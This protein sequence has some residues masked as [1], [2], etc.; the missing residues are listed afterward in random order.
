MYSPQSDTLDSSGLVK[1]EYP[2]TDYKDKGDS[3]NTNTPTTNQSTQANTNNGPNTPPAPQNNTAATSSGTNTNGDRDAISD[4]NVNIQPRWGDDDSLILTIRDLYLEPDSSTGLPT[5]SIKVEVLSE[6][7]VTEINVF[8]PSEW[9]GDA[10]GEKVDLT[11]IITKSNI[12]TYSDKNIWTE[13]SNEPPA[14]QVEIPLIYY[15]FTFFKAGEQDIVK[16]NFSYYFPCNDPNYLNPDGTYDQNEQYDFA[17]GEYQVGLAACR[18]KLNPNYN[19]L[20]S[21]PVPCP[22]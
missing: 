3:S 13:T 7:V 5:W 9:Y 8:E 21:A 10:G 2:T 22:F 19:D 14:D 6:S 17:I 1:G 20:S 15:R 18:C 11:T 4:A 16:D 12:D